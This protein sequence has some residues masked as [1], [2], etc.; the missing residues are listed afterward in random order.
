MEDFGCQ[1]DKIQLVRHAKILFC[2]TVVLKEMLLHAYGIQEIWANALDF[3]DLEG[4]A[5][6][7]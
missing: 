6:G 3:H 4:V 1:R 5:T 2:W 7:I